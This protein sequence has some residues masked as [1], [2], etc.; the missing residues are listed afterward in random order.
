MASVFKRNVSESSYDMLTQI[1]KHHAILWGKFRGEASP[2]MQKKSER[3][4]SRSDNFCG[5]IPKKRLFRWRSSKGRRSVGGEAAKGNHARHFDRSLQGR[6]QRNRSVSL[7][8]IAKGRCPFGQQNCERGQLRSQFC[9][10]EESKETGRFRGG[11]IQRG[12]HP[13]GTRPCLQGLVCYT[14]CGRGREKVAVAF[15]DCHLFRG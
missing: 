1:Q 4:R 2:L 12:R 13:R 15:L 11:G 9:C 5:K 14:F 6:I 7:A 3:S 10:G 8:G